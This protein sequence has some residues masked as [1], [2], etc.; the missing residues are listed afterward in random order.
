M[1]QK[2]TAI[3]CPFLF[4]LPNLHRVIKLGQKVIC[5]YSEQSDMLNW[6]GVGE[7][8]TMK[9]KKLYFMIFFAN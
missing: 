5:C 2:R 4:H 6:Y 8:N 7:A 3:C 1:K 9:K